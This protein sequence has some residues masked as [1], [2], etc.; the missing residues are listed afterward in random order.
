MARQLAVIPVVI[1]LA[2]TAGVTLN[3]EYATERTLRIEA[4]TSIEMETTSST[5]LRDGEEVEGRGGGAGA[6]SADARTVVQLDTVLAKEDGAP[7]KMR[8]V[9]ETVEGTSSRTM[10]EQTMDR[11]VESPFSGLGLVLSLEDGDV[12][13]EVEEG[14]EPDA[15]LLEGHRLDLA[16][17]ALLPDDE[18]SKDDTWELDADAIQRLLGLDMQAKLFPP[19]AVEE[20]P[21]GGEGRRGGGGRRGGMRGGG[22]MS[23]LQLLASDQWEGE[24]TLVEESEDT[25]EGTGAVI[26]FKATC[27]GDIP[28]PEG[29]GGGREEQFLAELIAT[30][31][32]VTVFENTFEVEVK[33]RMVFS[34]EDHRPLYLG[35]EADVTI[36][37]YREFGRG[38][39]QMSMESTQEGTFGYEVTVTIEEADGE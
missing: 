37:T 36:E 4:K 13:I 19:P 10:G 28:E 32:P 16:L 23:V 3:T 17:D 8:R 2:V 11:E 26:E 5:F 15:A 27:T 22:G 24:A 30:Y 35:T 9:Y 29:R 39:V 6:V 31:G 25:D 33:G 12:T 1:G 34:T 18:V 7:T 20:A 21:A 14:D 38:D